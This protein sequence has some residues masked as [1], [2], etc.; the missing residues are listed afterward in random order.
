MN[1]DEALANFEILKIL[2][3]GDTGR[4]RVEHRN[5]LQLRFTHQIVRF[6]SGDRSQKIEPLS[7]RC[8]LPRSIRTGTPRSDARSLSSLSLV[9]STP[10]T[11][12][13]YS[14]S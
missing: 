2:R 12:A 5:H 14:K 10:L 4:G 11:D 3:S 9:A 8:F 1:V 7:S 6:R 13:A